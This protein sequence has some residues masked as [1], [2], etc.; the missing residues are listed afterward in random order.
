MGDTVL[1]TE[2]KIPVDFDEIKGNPHRAADK[3]Y[4]NIEQ[5]YAQIRKAI[6]IFPDKG[7]L[8]VGSGHGFV[9]ILP[10]GANTYV[11]TCDDTEDLGLKWAPPDT[12]ALTTVGDL[13]FVNALGVVT[14]LPKGSAGQILEMASDASI[15]AWQSHGA[16]TQ[17]LF[18]DGTVIA[19]DAGLTYNKGTG[20]LTATG[21]SGPLTGNVTGNCSGSSTKLAIARAI[22]GTNFDGSA[23]ITTAL[24]GTAR[25]LTIGSKTQSVDGSAAV[26]W[27]LADIG[28]A[29]IAQTMYIGT[30]AAAINRA[31]AALTLANVHFSTSVNVGMGASTEDAAIQIGQGRTGD[32]NSYFDLIGDATY[33]DYGVRLIRYAG[34]N[35]VSGIYHRGTGALRYYTHEAATIDF[36]TASAH[37]MSIGA[38]GGVS[39]GAMTDPGDNNLLV[40]GT[41][42]CVGVATLGSIAFPTTAAAGGMLYASALNTMVVLAKGTAYQTLGMKSDASVP[43]WQASLKSVL[44]TTGDMVYASAAYTPARLAKGTAN[45]ILGMKADASVPEWQ[46]HGTDKQVLYNDGVVI[47]GNDSFTFDKSTNYLK[48]AEKIWDGIT[49]T[50]CDGGVTDNARSIRY[51]ASVGS[52]ASPDSTGSSVMHVEKYSSAAVGV[53]IQDDVAAT[54]GICK[55]SGSGLINALR[56]SAVA[57]GGTGEIYGFSGTAL[58]SAATGTNLSI[59]GGYLMAVNY[60]GQLKSLIGLEID[61]TDMYSS[62]TRMTDVNSI[63]ISQGISI[64]NGSTSHPINFAY[65]V[66]GWSWG[67]FHTGLMIA[68]DSITAGYEAIY[69]NGAS[70]SA[71]AYD[72]IVLTQQISIGL[73]MGNAAVNG[74]AIEMGR[75]DAGSTINYDTNDYTYF[76]SN[77]YKWMIGGNEVLSSNATQLKVTGD[78]TLTGNMYMANAKEI[79]FR[80]AANTAWISLIGCNSSNQVIVGWSSAGV[81]MNIGGTN[82]TLTVDGSG[83][84]KVL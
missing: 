20:V 10:V 50:L 75:S 64:L 11:L 25:N 27:T 47:S 2:W 22:N 44:T 58:S 6:H 23:D 12:S 54:F 33:T 68:K 9:D 36:Y 80:N 52:S 39:I 46:S 26:T 59:W 24:W 83:F 43:E 69:V 18:N 78:F 4:R 63:P 14:R 76:T 30:T 3:A 5:M 42:H 70:S 35:G 19:G 57:T 81:V 13:L 66:G 84:V 41:F 29:A 73:R 61:I 32:G 56:G 40:A 31:S 77:T 71:N 37:R 17:V 15:P 55:V 34:A 67:K 65:S 62:A 21:F 7:D 45:Q 72:G 74:Y 79:V 16:D 28:A 51:S 8:L 49:A 1:P 48:V 82:Y 60:G 53:G 38:T